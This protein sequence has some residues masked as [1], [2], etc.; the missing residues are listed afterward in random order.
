MT[1]TLPFWLTQIR[2]ETFAE[3]K[4]LNK[5]SK[6]RTVPNVSDLAGFPDPSSE[7]QAVS[8]IN[9]KV[10]TLHHLR[11]IVSQ[12]I[13][14]L[15]QPTISNKILLQNVF[16]DLRLYFSGTVRNSLDRRE[17][18]VSTPTRPKK[19]LTSPAQ[20]KGV[21]LRSEEAWREGYQ[22]RKGSP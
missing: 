7:W 15:S 5:S 16:T 3:A 6:I 9:H 17:K 22:L 2:E 14:P 20:T 10:G 18:E 19:I 8:T 4:G 11:P 1:T 12:I 13:S 21:R